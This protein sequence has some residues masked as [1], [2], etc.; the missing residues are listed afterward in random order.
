MSLECTNQE[1]PVCPECHEVLGDPSRMFLGAEFNATV[2]YVR[3]W[4]GKQIKVTM[5]RLYDTEVVL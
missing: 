5:K 4:C 1:L 3:C 2:D